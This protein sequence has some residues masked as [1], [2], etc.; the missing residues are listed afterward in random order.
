M[1]TNSSHFGFVKIIIFFTGVFIRQLRSACIAEELS[2]EICLL[3]GCQ[4][5]NGLVVLI[6][7]Y[8]SIVFVLFV[9]RLLFLDWSLYDW[10]ESFLSFIL[11]L[12]FSLFTLVNGFLIFIANQI[13]LIQLF[14]LLNLYNGPVLNWRELERSNNFW[15]SVFLN[16]ASF[17]F[18]MSLIIT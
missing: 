14:I 12:S 6:E 10:R 18:L 4:T 7:G 16:F 17:T 9:H 15:N 8:V 2:L 13:K 1:H 3:N 11:L 5:E